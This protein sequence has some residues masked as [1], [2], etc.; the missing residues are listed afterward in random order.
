MELAENHLEQQR[1][2]RKIF[3]HVDNNKHHLR[4]YISASAFS[5]T[6]VLL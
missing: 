6:G 2:M 4:T 3:L 5:K 1:R